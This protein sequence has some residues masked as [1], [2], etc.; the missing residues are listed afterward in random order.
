MKT[1][2]STHKAIQNSS[3]PG[4]GIF[5]FIPDFTLLTLWKIMMN[6][7][8][9]PMHSARKCDFVSST[10]YWNVP[11]DSNVSSVL[12]CILQAL[13]KRISSQLW[14]EQYN[15]VFIQIEVHFL[16]VAHPLHHQALG[17]QKWVELMIV[18]VLIE[19]HRTHLLSVIICRSTQDPN[20]SLLNWHCNSN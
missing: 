17:W 3:S 11:C 18:I 6:A 20:M 4:V 1:N 10:S 2:Q 12:Y 13:S 9:Q 7:K 8:S 14:S 15:T 5:K 19:R 16:I